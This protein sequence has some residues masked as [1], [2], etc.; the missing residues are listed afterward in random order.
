MIG[1]RRTILTT[2]VGLAAFAV[3]TRGF[4]GNRSIPVQFADARAAAPNFVG[5]SKW[6]NS[7]PLSISDLRGKVVL[8][9][10]WT[11]VTK[12]YETYKDKGLVVVGIHTPEFP[13]ERSAGNVQAALKRHGI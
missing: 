13:F 6:F 5:I 11:Y 10:F 2:F 8:V 1:S 7:A 3:A 4:A 12:L 9:D